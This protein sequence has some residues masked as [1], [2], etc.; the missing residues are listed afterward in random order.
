MPPE[1]VFYDGHCGLCH[2][3]VLFLVARDPEGTLFRYAPLFGPTF[4]DRVP[5]DRREGLA[6]SVI[7][8]CDDGTLLERAQGVFHTLRRIGGF[9]G[10]V[11]TVGSWLP[12]GLSDWGYDRMAAVRH[13]LFRRPEQACPRVPAEL[14]PRFLP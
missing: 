11:G 14:R 1:L 2:R 8:L 13:R 9:W 10:L 5:A 6:D 4:E 12:N 3:T 7:V